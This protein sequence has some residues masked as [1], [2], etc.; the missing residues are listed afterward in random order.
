MFRFDRRLLL[1]FDWGLLVTVLTIA[2]MGLANLYSA[3]YSPGAGASSYFI[4]QL[5]YYLLGFGLILIM[6]SIDY[7]ML[8]GLDGEFS[9]QPP[10]EIIYTI[11]S[12]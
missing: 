10:L 7:R 5:Y 11:M 1:N 12:D 4:K 8:L 9:S 2:V 6:I 3:T